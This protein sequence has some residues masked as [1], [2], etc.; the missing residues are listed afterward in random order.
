M[1]ARPL[2]ARTWNAS[3][4]GRADDLWDGV[5]DPGSPWQ[6]LFPPPD[7]KG[8]SGAPQTEHGDYPATGAGS[9]VLTACLPGSLGSTSRSPLGNSSVPPSTPAAMTRPRLR[10]P[11][12]GVREGPNYDRRDRCEDA[13]GQGQL[14]GAAAREWVRIRNGSLTVSR[15]GVRNIRRRRSQLHNRLDR[16]PKRATMSCH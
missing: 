13:A 3:H 5:V 16:C 8:L 9:R 11:A 6:C 4:S 1:A 14:R 12:A 10:P 2:G 15:D 7:A